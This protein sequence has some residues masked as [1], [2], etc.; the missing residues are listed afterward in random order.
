MGSIGS[1]TGGGPV[2]L[3]IANYSAG[4]VLVYR[5]GPEAQGYPVEYVTTVPPHNT[6]DPTESAAQ[7]Q[8]WMLESQGG[9]C[10]GVW[11]LNGSEPLI[12]GE[13]CYPGGNMTKCVPVTESPAKR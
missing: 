2:T 7:G 4:D 3:G 13:P 9:V 5:L 10:M 11:Q 1:T 12:S 8:V 6:A